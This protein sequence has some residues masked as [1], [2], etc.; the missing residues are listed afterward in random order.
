MGRL[1]VDVPARIAWTLNLL[2]GAP[3]AR[4]LEVGCG[5]GVA[6]ALVCDRLDWGRITA[7][8]RSSTAIERTRRRSADHMASCR[9]VLQQVDLAG[10]REAGRFDKSFAINVNVFWTSDADDELRVLTHVL[11]SGG[12]LRIVYGGPAPCTARSVGPGMPPSSNVTASP[13]R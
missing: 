11:R 7:I 6:V 13:P 12:V 5:P 2:D 3:S 9:A 4:I 8:D 1:A 10:L